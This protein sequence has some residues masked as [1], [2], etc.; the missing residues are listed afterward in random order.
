MLC[1]DFPVFVSVTSLGNEN[2]FW[3]FVALDISGRMLRVDP[4]RHCISICVS[5]CK[6]CMRKE[7]LRV[8]SFKHS[9]L[10]DVRK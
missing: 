8:E 2:R 6:G 9:S 5:E 3:I 10:V 1:C 7:A 4:R